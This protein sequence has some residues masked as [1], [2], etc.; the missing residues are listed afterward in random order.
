VEENSRNALRI[1]GDLLTKEG[2][3]VRPALRLKESPRARGNIRDQVRRT[4]KMIMMV[5]KSPE[6]QPAAVIWI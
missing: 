3:D 2:R 6:V 1:E 4:A 5:H